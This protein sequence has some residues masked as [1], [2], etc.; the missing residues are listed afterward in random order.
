MLKVF[1]TG[2]VK[3]YSESRPLYLKII[4]YLKQKGC[5]L[6]WNV[7]ETTDSR[8]KAKI[9]QLSISQWRTIYT[10]M[11]KS[12][13][14]SDVCILENTTSAFSTGYLA[15]IAL[16]FN[17]PTLVLFDQNSK[18]TFKTSFMHGILHPKLVVGEYRHILHLYKIIDEFLSLYEQEENTIDI[19]LKLTPNEKSFLDKTAKLMKTTRTAL[20]RKLIRDLMFRKDAD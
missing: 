3:R 16:S 8:I 1:F 14:E 11:I 18:H 20:I 17:I 6:T 2:S 19:H 7:V 15:G 13:K 10:D 9:T 4:N 12:L 5:T